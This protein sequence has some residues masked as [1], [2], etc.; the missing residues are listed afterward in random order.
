MFLG[1]N[2]LGTLTVILTMYNQKL[3][4]LIHRSHEE[5]DPQLGHPHRDQA[6]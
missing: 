6:P 5:D 4:H 2:M 1:L 3:Q